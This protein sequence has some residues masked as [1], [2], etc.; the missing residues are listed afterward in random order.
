MTTS[1]S[2]TSD[3]PDVSARSVRFPFPV[4]LDRPF[5]QRVSETYW[6]GEQRVTDWSRPQDWTSVLDIT[7]PR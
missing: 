1:L 4:R 5:R 7:T 3:A 6:S 2:F